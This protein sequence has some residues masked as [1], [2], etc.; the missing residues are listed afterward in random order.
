MSKRREGRGQCDNVGMA[1]PIGV[2]GEYCCL[3]NISDVDDTL[4]CFV[5]RRCGIGDH[6]LEAELEARGRAIGAPRSPWQSNDVSLHTMQNK[7][8]WEISVI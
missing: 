6:F 3:Y 5:N 1:E 2:V 4:A 7:Y 8:H